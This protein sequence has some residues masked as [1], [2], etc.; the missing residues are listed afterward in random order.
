MRIVPGNVGRMVAARVMLAW[1][2]LS[3]AAGAVT[4][5]I[6]LE[7]VNARVLGLA[8]SE[9]KRFTEHIVAIGPEHREELEEQ[10][11]EFLQGDFISLR[12]YDLDKKKI[13]EAFDPGGKDPRRRLPEHV[14]DLAPG[15]LDHHHMSWVD[16]RPLMQLLLPVADAGGAALGYFEGV[17]E[18]DAGTLGDII[19]RTAASLALALGVVLVTTAVLYSVI[20]A[21][22]RRL[23]GL[24]SDLLKSNTELMEVLGS[25]VAL[26]DSDTDAHNYR[27]TA[28]AIGMGKALRLPARELRDLIAGAFLH[29][30]G[31]IGISDAILLKPG[32]LTPAEME[33][34]RRH[35]SLGVGVLANSGWLSGARDVVE[36]HHE[37]FDGA[38]YPKGLAAGAIPLV[39]RIF[40]IMDVFDALMSRRPYKEAL[41]FG[42]AMAVLERGR[43]THFDPALLDVFH[44]IAAGLREHIGALDESALRTSVR[45][46]VAEHFRLASA[47]APG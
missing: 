14:H 16:G 28:Y 38:G 36:F 20:A 25:A 21:L 23:V 17:Y 37:R 33:A 45:S 4:L 10:A 8:A 46:Q 26:R 15:E 19:A 43:G 47:A 3:L 6:E 7:R 35:V 18:V 39:A 32:P 27:V 13:L 2:A 40:A 12:L 1:A 22:N 41:P 24:S 42:E 30:V 9:S 31:K 5:Y 29:D 34:I 11:A 44:S